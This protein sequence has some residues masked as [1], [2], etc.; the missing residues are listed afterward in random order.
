MTHL[1]LISQFVMAGVFAL[2]AFGKLREQPAFVRSLADFR[3]PVRVRGPVAA[4]VTGAEAAVVPLALVPDTAPVGLA[5][6]VV[7]LVIF[8]AVIGVTLRRG[9]RPRCRCFGAG[10]AALRGA[11]IVRNLVLA[12]LAAAGAVIAV[13]IEPVVLPVGSLVV[14]GVLG[15]VLVAVVAGFDDLLDVVAPGG[16]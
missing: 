3:V 13:T 7:L 12:A 15:A 2:S 1:L 16:A 9:H 6:G 11:H 5:L 4:A 14:L 8:A 10:R